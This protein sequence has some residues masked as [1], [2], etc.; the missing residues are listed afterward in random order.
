MKR[1][2]LIALS[3]TA[4]VLL[5]CGS[6]PKFV[7]YKT[8]PTPTS[9]TASFVAAPSP[10][11]RGPGADLPSL[12]GFNLVVTRTQQDCSSGDGC[13]IE[14]HIEVKIDEVLVD[15]P[16]MYLVTYEVDGVMDGPVANTFTIQGG[17]YTR[18]GDEY[19]RTQVPDAPLEVTP[20]S[21]ERVE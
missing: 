15:D 13:D 5:A 12:D 7:P 9:P 11:V 2:Y 20:T 14:Y 19:A 21:I 17:R 18:Q 3:G 1:W 4:A 8:V 10:A 6:T 16:G